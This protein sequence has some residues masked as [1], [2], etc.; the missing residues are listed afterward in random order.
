M[1]CID[2]YVFQRIVLL[3][4]IRMLNAEKFVGWLYT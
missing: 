4:C 3:F 2:T 1:M